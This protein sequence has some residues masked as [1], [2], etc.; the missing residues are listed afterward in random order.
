MVRWLPALAILATATGCGLSA[1]WYQKYGIASQADLT[2]AESVSKLIDVLEKKDCDEVEAVANALARIEPPPVEAAPAL[3]AHLDR[4][5]CGADGLGHYNPQAA[6]IVRALG[7]LNPSLAASKVVSL[8]NADHGHA[9]RDWALALQGLGYTGGEVISALEFMSANDPE[10]ESKRAA[11][12]ALSSLKALAAQGGGSVGAAGQRGSPKAAA[13]S[14]SRSV[15]V[16]L[17]DVQDPSKQFKPDTLEQLTEYLSTRLTQSGRF[18]VVPRDQLRERLVAQKT[19]SYKS[20]YDQ[21][22][23]IELG[24]A[25]AAE[26]SAA[27]KLLRVGSKCA[28]TASLFDLASETTELGAST[29]TNCS[30][31]ALMDGM[32]Q[33]ARQ[34]SG[35]P[36]AEK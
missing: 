8:L 27:V 25:I 14:R 34:L 18:R 13:P 11:G 21:T 5:S 17:F 23:Q 4:N 12:I 24:K 20:C 32:D 6:A 30:D 31:D 10:E 33:V 26:K 28:I 35:E 29:R 7:R 22:C 3:A 1:T 19:E 2:K 15:I 36:A 16:A 9:R